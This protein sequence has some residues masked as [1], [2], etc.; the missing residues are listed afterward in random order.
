M[1]RTHT[2]LKKLPDAPGVY[3]FVGAKREVLYVGKA[4]SLKDRVKSYFAPDLAATRG[5]HMSRMVERARRVDF[6]Q[7]DSVLEA[8]ILEAKL[9]K[10]L[11]PQYNSRDKDDKSFNY[12][13]IT[14][15]EQYPRLL[16]VR[17]KEL[18]VV[19]R[20]LAG[21]QG[22]RHVP[23]HSSHISS[24]V[25][26]HSSL[27]VF[28][29]FVHAAQFKEALKIIRKIFPYYDTTYP[30][31]VLRDH[32]DRKLRFNE[33]IGVYP[34]ADTSA[35]AY[36]RTVR[37]IML[38]F[39]GK[40]PQLMRTLERDMKRYAKSQAFELAAIAKRQ[41][42]A[43]RHIEDVSLIRRE[44]LVPG[45]EGAGYRIE[46]Y[47]VAHMA[48]NDM[49]GVMTVVA[50]G[51]PNKREYRTFTVRTVTKSNDTAALREVLLRRL[52][53]PEWQYPRL[54]V[55]DGGTAQLAAARKVLAE[56]GVVL[57]VVAVTKDAHHRPK[58][59]QGPARVRQEHHRAILLANAEA[60][61]FSLAVHTRRRAKRMRM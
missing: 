4:T 11:K 27:P 32:D 39:E 7:T 25:T 15:N 45:V 30:V 52:T 42:F 12:L 58:A 10:E 17:G 51:E 24:L 57:P 26:H 16:T 6:R 23:V 49:V 43:L 2:S 19:L 34:G 18:A 53:H 41:L 50:D 36:R 22:G 44:R 61:R 9:I 21:G 37:H 46:G 31:D 13:V 35:A 1:E 3:F 59:I 56:A 28:G 48:G 60:H 38:I 5:S 14:M 54:I 55:V 47:D 33:S 20:D 29:P 8:L 40:K